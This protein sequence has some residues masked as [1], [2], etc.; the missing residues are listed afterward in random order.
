MRVRANFIVAIATSGTI[1]FSPFARAEEF[2]QV[3]G[4]PCGELCR[5]WMGIKLP[6]KPKEAVAES[7]KPR[8]LT[9]TPHRVTTAEEGDRDTPRAHKT[10]RAT[11]AA[12]GAKPDRS[13]SARPATNP[14]RA[15]VSA[16]PV[17]VGA[18]AKAGDQAPPPPAV[19]TMATNNPIPREPEK[20]ADA[21]KPDA[22]AQSIAATPAPVA[23]E[24]VA[25]KPD[26]PT[27]APSVAAAPTPAASETGGV[28][29]KS[30]DAVKP[31][32]TAPGVAAAPAPVASETPSIAPPL[33][34]TKSAI[35]PR[36]LTAPR[37]E[38][39]SRMRLRL[40]RAKTGRRFWSSWRGQRS[41]AS[42]IFKASRSS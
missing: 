14:A 30:T 31:D 35:P 40:R 37:R 25:V 26:V 20:P 4:L 21:A 10:R 29:E 27:P 5:A 3:N 39:K 6:L 7:A 17:R 13:A 36:A 34:A 38:P 12:G 18:D 28:A 33:E 22:P 42:R 15:D 41:R 2:I 32:A 9:A 16:G 19:A 11:D 8:K 1:S 24:T 23:G